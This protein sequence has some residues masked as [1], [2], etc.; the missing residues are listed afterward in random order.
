MIVSRS[1]PIGGVQ[2]VRRIVRRSRRNNFRP[3][4]LW[5]ADKALALDM[6]ED[7][8]T[9]LEV[10]LNRDTRYVFEVTPC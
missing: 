9:Q 4:V 3:L 8:A 5:H 1:H 10:Y 2:Y 6:P 7:E